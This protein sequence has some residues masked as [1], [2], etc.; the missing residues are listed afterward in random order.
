[1]D[2]ER[3]G[4]RTHRP[5]RRASQTVASP[6]MAEQLRQRAEDAEL[7]YREFVVP[8]VDEEVAVRESRRFTNALK[9]S[10]L[11]HRKSLDEFDFAFQPDLDAR[12]SKTSPP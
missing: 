2:G 1:M 8:V 3:A 11:P 9:L 10:G 4:R 7:G 5:P 6:E 12:R